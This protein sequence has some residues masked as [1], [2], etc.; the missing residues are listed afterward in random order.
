[1]SPPGFRSVDTETSTPVAFDSPARLLKRDSNVE[2]TACADLS[3]TL[4]HVRVSLSKRPLLNSSCPMGF[5]PFGVLW[6]I[7]QLFAVSSRSSVDEPQPKMRFRTDSAEAPGESEAH[8]IDM[9]S[10]SAREQLAAITTKRRETIHICS[11]PIVCICAITTAGRVA[12][13]T[14]TRASDMVA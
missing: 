1:M 14:V 5:H 6:P 8:A 13:S 4:E 12:R 9:G 3:W 2:V 11:P 10:A 7:R